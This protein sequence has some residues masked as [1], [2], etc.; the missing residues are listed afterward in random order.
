MWTS[1]HSHFSTE[2]LLF[3]HSTSYLPR[4]RPKSCQNPPLHKHLPPR[5]C[6]SDNRHDSLMGLPAFREYLLTATGRPALLSHPGLSALRVDGESSIWRLRIARKDI[7]LK[8]WRGML[9]SGPPFSSFIQHARCQSQM[10]F[11]FTI[12]VLCRRLIWWLEKKARRHNAQNAVQ[13]C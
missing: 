1:L 9:W 3:W 12:S 13:A 8:L 10:P 2:S 5:I 4:W 7:C 11:R 6:F